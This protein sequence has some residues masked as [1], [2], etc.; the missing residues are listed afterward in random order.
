LVLAGLWLLGPAFLAYQHDPYWTVVVWA[1]AGAI[2]YMW[3]ARHWLA[4]SFVARM[5]Q[6]PVW[7]AVLIAGFMLITV[8]STAIESAIYFVAVATR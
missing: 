2:A 4:Q 3:R 1:L 5:E 6:N 8:E 7:I